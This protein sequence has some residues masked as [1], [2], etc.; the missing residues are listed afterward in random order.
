MSSDA[1]KK[2][3]FFSC[4][5]L[6]VVFAR[7]CPAKDL[8]SAKMVGLRFGV[9]NA[10]NARHVEPAPG[11]DILTEVTAPYGEIHFSLG[12]ENGLAVGISMGS[13]YRGETRYNDPYGY[14]WKRVTVYP[15]SG[16][17]KYYPLYRV[18]KSRWQPYV[19]GGM[20]L[21]SGTENI[22]FGEYVGP[23]LYLGDRTDTYLTFGW[24]AGAG[25]DF[26]LSRS[27]ALG[28]DF[29]YRGVRFG[30]EVGG[31]KDYSGPEAALGIC[32]ILTGL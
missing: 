16:E 31:M 19:D 26:V 5:T 12:L 17:L 32:Y 15:I 20:G 21:V 30:D 4:V 28:F 22:R 7:V 18:E 2:L 23:L 25:M 6:S 14:Y 8:S 27:F 29:K 1:M 10:V 13:C 3:L 24:H 11:E 9:W